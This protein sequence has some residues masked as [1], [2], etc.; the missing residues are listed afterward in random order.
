MNAPSRVA[1][2]VGD[3]NPPTPG[4]VEGL[5]ERSRADP[6]TVVVLDV[7]LPDPNA[8]RVARRVAEIARRKTAERLELEAIARRAAALVNDFTNLL[9]PIRLQLA[10]NA[11]EQEDGASE[12]LQQIGLAADRAAAMTRQLLPFSRDQPS[13]GDEK[14]EDEG[15]GT[16][17]GIRRPRQ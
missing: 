11:F 17:N 15:T 3:D 6:P 16:N 12:G 8:L 7:R 4:A 1:W 10:L 9:V 2:V 14:P 13:P 5:L